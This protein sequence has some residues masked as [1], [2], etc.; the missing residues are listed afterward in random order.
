MRLYKDSRLKPQYMEG[1]THPKVMMLRYTFGNGAVIYH[2]T[3]TYAI[4]LF[5]WPKHLTEQANVTS[6]DMFDRVIV[7]TTNSCNPPVKTTFAEDMKSLLTQK[8]GVTCQQPEGPSFESYA[9]IFRQP[10]LYVSTICPKVREGALCVF[11]FFVKKNLFL[12]D[13]FC[14]TKGLDVRNLCKKTCTRR[15]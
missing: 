4:H 1:W 2:A 7:G 10:L 5:D 9:S 15:L 14:V 8:Y 13:G 6:L 3:N 12:T 11:F